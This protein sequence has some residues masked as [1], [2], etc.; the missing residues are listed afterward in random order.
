MD[1]ALGVRHTILR[2]PHEPQQPRGGKEAQ[3]HDHQ[4]QHAGKGDAGMEGIPGSLTVSPAVK[5]GQKHCGAG[6]QAD[7]K[8]IEQADQGS[9]G[10]NS[11]QSLGSHIPSDNDG[12]HRIIKLLEKGPQQNGEEKAEKLLPDHAFGD[13]GS[14][15]DALHVGSL[16]FVILRYSSMERKDCPAV[17]QKNSLK[18]IENPVLKSALL[19][20]SPVIL[21]SPSKR[22]V[23]GNVSDALCRRT[24]SGL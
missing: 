2:R 10:A 3:G 11:R 1:V 13:P 18:K 4:A 9:R 5:L 7:E 20:Q 14:S 23:D 15:G 6:A 24:C 17:S 16:P 19:D 8:A 22:K 12:I 21:S